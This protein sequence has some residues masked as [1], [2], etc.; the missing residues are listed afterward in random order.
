MRLHALDHVIRML[1]MYIEYS[2][3]NSNC[4]SSKTKEVN[5]S[6]GV[7]FEYLPAK[8]QLWTFTDLNRKCGNVKAEIKNQVFLLIPS[9][10]DSGQMKNRA[11]KIPGTRNLR[12]TIFQAVEVSGRR[13]PRQMRSQVNWASATRGIKQKSS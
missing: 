4:N 8:K 7:S 2:N 10:R 13:A 3:T 12:Q 9:R 1:C 5:N 11:D 6:W